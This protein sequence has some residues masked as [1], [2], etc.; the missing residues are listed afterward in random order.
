MVSIVTPVH[1]TASHLAECIESVLNQ[2]YSNWEH[3]IV[4]NAST[5]GSGEIATRYARQDDRI[6]VV[7]FSELLPQVPNYNRT[8]AQAS[9]GCAYVKVLEADNWLFPTCLEE[10]VALAEAHPNV[11]IVSAYNST[12]TK[13]RF[14]GLPLAQT[15]VNGRELAR[16]H[17][18]A[19]SY[20]FGAP[21]TVLMRASFVLASPKFYDEEQWIAEDLSACFNALREWDFGFVHQ[22]LTFVR[23]E[24]DS[25]LSRIKG[26]DAQFLDRL[27]LLR[28]HGRDF[29]SEVEFATTQESLLRAYY[30][31]LARG[32]LARQ[33]AT[34]WTFHRRGAQSAGLELDRTRLAVAI[35]RE[36]LA[37]LASPVDA[38]R[39]VLRS[40]R[41]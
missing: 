34:F 35:L 7:S 9:R 18:R 19:D 1:N 27:V 32:A 17:L 3:V 6:R 28:R 23:T 8:I 2:R 13:I 29:M 16:M 36:L 25:I 26:F 40:V 30:G 38:I 12:E 21:T 22:I 11:G 14:T 10:M 39:Q 20:L 33:G 41:K 37:H 5:D 15:V 4:D 24:N 31:C